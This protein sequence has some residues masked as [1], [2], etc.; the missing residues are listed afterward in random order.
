M[1]NP[2]ATTRRGYGGDHQRERR[3]W[4]VVVERGDGPA[5]TRCG[6]P[7]L[8]HQAWHLDHSEDRT[9]WLGVAHR[10]CNLRAGGRKA[11]RVGRAVRRVLRRQAPA[12]IKVVDGRT[13]QLIAGEWV[14][15]PEGVSR[16]SR[17][18]FDVE[19]A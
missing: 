12:D 6:F 16:W 14:L 1:S 4:K 13:Y 17:K 8:A 19:A 5:C 11:H 9:E 15:L 18:W 2:G 10:L 3:R 7:V